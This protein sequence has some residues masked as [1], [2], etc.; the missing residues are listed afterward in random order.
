MDGPVGSTGYATATAELHA[1]DRSTTAANGPRKNF[2]GPPAGRLTPAPIRWLTAALCVVVAAWQTPRSAL[3]GVIHNVEAENV[4][5]TIY[6]NDFF[7]PAAILK[8]DKVFTDQQRI[9]F[10]RVKLL[11]VMVAQGVRLELGPSVTDTNGL[12]TF[13]FKP[14]T[15]RKSSR[16]EWRDISV[17]LPKETEPRLRAKRLYCVGSGQSEFLQ[18]EGV[19][20]QTDAGPLKVPRAKLLLNGKPGCVLWESSGATSQ[21]D[22]FARKLNPDTKPR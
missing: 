9:G 11:P 2:I 17:S 15:A 1:T 19:T 4:E 10:F 18:L 16:M 7:Q 22:L 20:L 12:A 14:A 5:T 13:H 21:W 8:I 6:G 3:A